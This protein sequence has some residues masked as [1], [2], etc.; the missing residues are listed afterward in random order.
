MQDAFAAYPEL[1]CI[2][3][4]YKLLE[5]GYPVYLIICEDSNGQSE[6]IAVT[7]LVTE[8]EDSINWMMSSFKKNN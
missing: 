8:D 2:D 5:L 3:A 6:V 1:I 7:L 4:T